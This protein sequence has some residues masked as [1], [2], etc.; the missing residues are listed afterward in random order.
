MFSR[1][2]FIKYLTD[3]SQLNIQAKDIDAVISAGDQ[4]QQMINIECLNEF[5]EVPNLRIQFMLVLV[6]NIL[7]RN[8]NLFY[9]LIC[10][11][12]DL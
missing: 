10:Y 8:I 3:C 1:D 5:D 9:Y 11:S 2:F 4:K 6:V 12:I 7:I